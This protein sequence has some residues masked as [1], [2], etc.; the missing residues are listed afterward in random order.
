MRIKNKLTI[1][2]MDKKQF[3]PNKYYSAASI[4]QSNLIS[5]RR[6]HSLPLLST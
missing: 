1:Y 2:N 4:L 5:N 6:L 3:N